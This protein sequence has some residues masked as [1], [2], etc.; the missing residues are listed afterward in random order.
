MKTFTR[1]A[2]IISFAF[3]SLS[4]V[5][6]LLPA[7]SAPRSEGVLFVAMGLFLVGLAFFF[8]AMLWIV[9]EKCCS[10]QNGK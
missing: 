7:L 4:G 2:A 5:C 10:K 6:I 1:T 8:G 3:C 9:G